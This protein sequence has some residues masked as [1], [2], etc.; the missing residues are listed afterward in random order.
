MTM[1]VHD[2]SPRWRTFLNQAKEKEITLLLSQQTHTPVVEVSFHDLTG[3]DPDFAEDILNE[4]RQILG[5]GSATLSDICK[6]R[7]VDLEAMVRVSDLKRD[8]RRPLREIGSSDIEKL[9]RVDVSV[10]KVS[11]LKPRIHRAVFICQKCGCTIEVDQKNERELEEPL[12]CPPETGCG[13][14]ARE[15]RF[16]LVMNLSRM[17]N[18]QWLEVQELP[19]NVPSGAQ[20]RRGITLVEGDLVNKHLPG[21]RITANVIPVVHSE[22]KNR[23]KTPMFDIIYHL[24]SSEHESVPFTEIKI[25]EE[26]RDVIMEVSQRED[27]VTLMQRSIAPSIFA[28]RVMNHVKRSLALQLF[29][30]VRRSTSDKSHLRGD[31]HILLM[32]DPGVAKS[33][34][35]S[36]MSNLAPRGKLASGGGVTG[37]GLTAAAVKDAFGDGRFALEAGVLPLSDKGLAAIDEFDKITKEDRSAIHPAMEQQQIHVAKGGITATLPARCAVLA[38]AN[39]K[40]GRFSR[41]GPNQSVLRMYE[42]TGLPAPLASR[43]DIIWMIRDEVKA[44][45]DARIAKHILDTRTSAMSEV[46]MEESMEID[47]SEPDKDQVYSVGVDGHEHLTLDFLRKYVAYAKRHVHPDLDD[48]AKTAIHEYYISERQSYG[49]EDGS[50][51]APVPVTARALEALIRLTEAHARM[52]LRQVA[53]KRD[54]SVA[55]AVFKHWRDESGIEDDSELYSGVPHRQR[56]ANTVIRQVVRDICQETDGTAELTD[57]LNRCRARDLTEQTVEEALSKMRM[58]GE[59]FMPRNDTYSFAR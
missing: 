54:A 21:E 53:T 42:E 23:K 51:E 55:L 45:D 12:E 41:R 18:N 19:E 3:F 50:D 48:D 27:L 1:A 15:T 14:S 32:G 39:P 34:L 4:P 29:G 24:V 10:T 25:N 17:I 13:S 9:R 16:K 35:L 33:Q 46:K 26:D 38:A 56:N 6:E 40:E 49:R 44:E 47:P 31:I 37:A 57:I 20:P 30:G 36:Y 11:E 43:F 2:S 7:G 52:H 28:T 22:V 8:S 5:S 58:S 59:L